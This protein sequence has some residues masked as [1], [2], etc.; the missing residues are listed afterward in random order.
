[1]LAWPCWTWEALTHRKPSA[2]QLL[3]TKCGAVGRA[4]EQAISTKWDENASLHLL[5][6]CALTR[7]EHGEEV[8]TSPGR[9]A[10]PA[11]DNSQPKPLLH[12]QFPRQS[13]SLYQKTLLL[14]VLR[15]LDDLNES[16]TD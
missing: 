5:A 16:F 4:N 13:P 2:S 7:P 15:V 1:M 6:R 12:H 14:Q 3:H 9:M 10:R 8:K 11:W